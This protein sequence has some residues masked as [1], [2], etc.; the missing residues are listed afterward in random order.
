VTRKGIKNKLVK[1]HKNNTTKFKP[2]SVARTS[3]TL[4]TQSC[5]GVNG[6]E[7]ERAYNSET[8]IDAIGE[9]EG[10]DINAASLA[11]VQ[12]TNAETKNTIEPQDDTKSHTMED[13]EEDEEITPD[14]SFY[15][16]YVKKISEESIRAQI[17]AY[18]CYI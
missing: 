13:E 16:R 1:T 10:D 2:R 3:T 18:P 7:S 5:A 6:S 11:E 4:S 15:E 8:E 9:H 14:D 12:H 17:K